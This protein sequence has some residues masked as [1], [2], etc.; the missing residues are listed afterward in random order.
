MHLSATRENVFDALCFY[1]ENA[2]NEPEKR[3]T[4]L[5]LPVFRLI[6]GDDFNLLVTILGVLRGKKDTF[7]EEG[8]SWSLVETARTNRSIPNTSAGQ[9][10]SKSLKTPCEIVN[11]CMTNPNAP[12]CINRPQLLQWWNE[13]DD[14]PKRTREPTYDDYNSMCVQKYNQTYTVVEPIEIAT[15]Y[16]FVDVY[17][18]SKKRTGKPFNI[19]K[20]NGPKRDSSGFDSD[21]DSEENSDSEEDSDD[22]N[23]KIVTS[24]KTLLEAC[25]EA[26]DLQKTHNDFETEVLFDSFLAVERRG[27]GSRKID[28]ISKEFFNVSRATPELITAWGICK[29]N[30]SQER[31]AL[32]DKSYANTKQILMKSLQNL[33][34][35][36]SWSTQDIPDYSKV[37]EKLY[38][39]PRNKD[40]INF[41]QNN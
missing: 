21:S 31:D 40:Y 24:R 23:F 5:I 4:S 27:L 35:R 7:V 29:N 39:L 13:N 34:R 17:G 25:E 32:S 3:T 33:F 16:Y 8:Y 11:Q 30:A 19:L 1:L 15:R 20:T 2:K 12:E 37:Y 36:F 14:F 9:S 10:R 38:V 18:L 22:K 41:H 26:N 6:F 28:T